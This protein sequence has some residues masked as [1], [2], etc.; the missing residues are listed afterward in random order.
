MA[1]KSINCFFSYSLSV[2]RPN[3]SSWPGENGKG[4][5][6]P[7]EQEKLKEEKFKLNQFNLLASDMIALNRS[8]NDVRLDGYVVGSFAALN[9]TQCSFLFF[10]NRF[11]FVLFVQMSSKEVS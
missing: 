8:I 6:I 9:K 3:P 2:V 10:A 1:N 4:V 5:D 7:K 11:I